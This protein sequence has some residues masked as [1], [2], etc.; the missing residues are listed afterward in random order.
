MERALE[1][2]DLIE[3]ARLFSEDLYAQNQ[4]E[5]PNGESPFYKVS[6]G[7]KYRPKDAVTLLLDTSP[8][9][10][11]HKE[12]MFASFTSW[13]ILPN[14]P[15]VRLELIGLC[16][17]RLLAK[18]EAIASEDFSEN[19]ILMRDLIARHLIA[20]PQFI[21][22]IYVPFGGGMELLS[23]FGS[24]TIADHLF[25]DE[26]KSFYTILKMMASCLYVA[27][28]TSEDG[29]V[30]PTVNKAVATVRTFIDPKIMSRASIYA[31]WAECKDTIAWIC[32]AES[33]E[34]EIGTLL[35]K[36]LQANA[37]FEEHGKLFEKWARRAKFFCEHVLRRM[38][39]S[40]LYEANIRPLRK[41]EPERFSLNL[42]TPSDVAFTK[43]AYSL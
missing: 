32:A 31:K 16:I 17:K 14:D 39:D 21:E 25:D 42:L 6:L 34:L 11:G 12:V 15:N 33:I 29:S 30:Q 18:A 2:I 28:C 22:Q 24:R 10:F 35:D 27:S 40:E 5:R 19:S 7:D 38:P 3:K 8:S 43:K 4:I 41:V 23:D 26:R 1:R 37:T 13:V 9:F 20:G 36:L